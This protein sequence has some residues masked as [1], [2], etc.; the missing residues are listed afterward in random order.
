MFLN[1]YPITFMRVNISENFSPVY[2]D[3]TTKK[4]ALT[5]LTNVR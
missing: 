3:N 5:L 1:M 4:I 2:H